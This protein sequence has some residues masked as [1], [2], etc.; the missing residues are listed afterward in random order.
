MLNISCIGRSSLEPGMTMVEVMLKA[1]LD[2]D[3]FGDHA[4]V[5]V[6]RFSFTTQLLDKPS[7][8]KDD[9]MPSWQMLV[10]LMYPRL[11]QV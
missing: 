1:V 8:N 4:S 2:M 6:Q 9:V 10:L 5:V 7:S 3:H 11:R